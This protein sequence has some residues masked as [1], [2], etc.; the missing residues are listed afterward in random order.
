MIFKSQSK[1]NVF[2][3]LIM[4][5]AFLAVPEA[6]AQRKKRNKKKKDATEQEL[7]VREVNPAYFCFEKKWMLEKLSELKNENAQSEYYLTDLVQMAF[8]EGHC[9]ESVQ[10]EAREALG[11][12]TPE[13][14]AVLESFLE[15]K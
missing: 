9:I 4:L 5:I 11:A 6:N 10:I 13:Q 7:S 12:N 3:V 1:S 8:D 14:L 15:K 2:F